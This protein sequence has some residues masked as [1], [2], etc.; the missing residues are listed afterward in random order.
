MDGED[1]NVEVKKEHEGIIDV[2]SPVSGG[3]LGGII[4]DTHVHKVSK[5]IGWSK[6]AKNPEGTRKILEGISPPE[7][8]DELTVLLIGNH[9]H[10]FSFL[11]EQ[12]LRL[13]Y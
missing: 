5:R 10:H 7:H 6:G 1:L 13:V 3:N 11:I 8:W 12:S 2:T 4:V 9:R